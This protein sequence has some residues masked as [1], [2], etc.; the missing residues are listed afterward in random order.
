MTLGSQA[1]FIASLKKATRQEWVFV[2]I[3]GPATILGLFGL[4]YVPSLFKI[5]SK[6]A[7]TVAIFVP[8]LIWWLV[9]LVVIAQATKRRIRSLNLLCP[10]CKKPLAGRMGQIVVA[11]GNCCHCGAKVVD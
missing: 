5:S 11:T 3:W 8:V 10:H 9:S 2:A 6:S 1:D 4:L 7:R